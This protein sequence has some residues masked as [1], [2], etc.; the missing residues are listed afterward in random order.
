MIFSKLINYKKSLRNA[1]EK[2]NAVRDRL[3]NNGVIIEH[4]DF[5]DLIGVYDRKTA[6]FYLDPPYYKAEGYYIKLTFHKLYP[7]CLNQLEINSRFTM[8]KA[9]L[10]AF[11][12]FLSVL[13]LAFLK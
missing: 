10:I 2:I 5:E 8:L 3:Y 1:V 11:S 4:K 13:D 9:N 6:F 12:S 7:Q